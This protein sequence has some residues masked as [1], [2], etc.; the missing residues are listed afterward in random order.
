M[1][2]LTKVLWTCCFALLVGTLCLISPVYAQVTFVPSG[3]PQAV[4]RG[5]AQKVELRVRNEGWEDER[6]TLSL[7]LW[8][9]LASTAAPLGDAEP[10]GEVVVPAR[11]TVTREVPLT[12]PEDCGPQVLVQWLVDDA[13]ALGA[14]RV[15]VVSADTLKE[16]SVLAGK[17]PL[18]LYD[19]ENVLKPALLKANVRFVEL[20]RPEDVTGETRLAILGPFSVSGEE[21]PQL[22]RLIRKALRRVPAVIS[23]QAPRKTSPLREE[24]VELIRENGRGEARFPSGFLRDPA[25]NARSQ[26]RLLELVRLSLQSNSE[27]LT[28]SRP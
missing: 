26:L 11:A 5:A 18:L 28:P 2:E 3:T 6:V 10:A 13:K 1:G 8:R 21:I 14:E 4:F 20:R 24:L 23:P 27:P 7:R 12:V 22:P 9:P 16:I 15:A 17:A 25:A 19:P